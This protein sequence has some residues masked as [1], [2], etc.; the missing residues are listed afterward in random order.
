MRP[1]LNKK[2]KQY[3]YILVNAIEFQRDSIANEIIY[4]LPCQYLKDITSL[5]VTIP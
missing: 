5:V 1:S 2:K 3:T 4:P